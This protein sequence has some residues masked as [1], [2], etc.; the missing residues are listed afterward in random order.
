MY[1]AWHKYSLHHF[2]SDNRS[3]NILI[4]PAQFLAERVF[5]YMKLRSIHRHVILISCFVNMLSQCKCIE[6]WFMNLLYGKVLYVNRD[7]YDKL[8]SR[9]ILCAVHVERRVQCACINLPGVQ[10]IHAYIR[11]PSLVT[12]VSVK[13]VPKYK[14]FSRTCASN[15]AFHQQIQ[16]PQVQMYQIN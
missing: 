5:N 9:N 13:Y 4:L 12:P 10:S 7:Q 3:S 11:T 16:F 8:S 1:L 14:I 15:F 6:S 2:F